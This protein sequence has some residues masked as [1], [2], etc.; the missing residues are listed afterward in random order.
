MRNNNEFHVGEVRIIE[1]ENVDEWIEKF[2]Q[3]V[4]DSESRRVL[5]T[6]EQEM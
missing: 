2:L 4:L 3:V 6:E 5:Q 1:P